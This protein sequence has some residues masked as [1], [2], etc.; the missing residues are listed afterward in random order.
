M[1]TFHVSFNDLSH[2]TVYLFVLSWLS[3]F[4][5][6]KKTGDRRFKLSL[7][8][9][10]S[11]MIF[12]ITSIAYFNRTDGQAGLIWIIPANF[13][14]AVSWLFRVSRTVNSLRR[15][16][17]VWPA[18]F[19]LVMGGLQYFLFGTLFDLLWGQLYPRKKSLDKRS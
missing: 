10:H 16:I 8:A 18:L 6:F 7:V 11:L 5:F 3:F 9:A 14:F 19:F 4:Y 15:S 1:N 2:L 17:V 13:D 12:W